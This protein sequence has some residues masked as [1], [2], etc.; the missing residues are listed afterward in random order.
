[1]ADKKDEDGV[2]VQLFPRLSDD[3]ICIM[4]NERMQNACALVDSLVEDLNDAIKTAE[5]EPPHDPIFA[6]GKLTQYLKSL[7][8]DEVRHLL[9]GA[10][11]RQAD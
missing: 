2:I 1:M 9:A 6:Y 3:D 10:L 4:L 11:W 7:S 8:D 5:N